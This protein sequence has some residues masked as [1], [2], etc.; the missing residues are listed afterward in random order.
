MNQHILKKSIFSIED[1]TVIVQFITNV[2]C[3]TTFPFISKKCKET[4]D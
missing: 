3:I 4:F 1:F 2:D